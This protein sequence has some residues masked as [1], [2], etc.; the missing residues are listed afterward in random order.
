MARPIT[1]QDVAG[2]AQ[3]PGILLAANQATKTLTDNI[4]GMGD[5]LRQVGA[6]QK[7]AATGAAVASI[8]N[9]EN[10]MA[11]MA[12]LPQDNKFID[13]LAVSVAANA[14]TDQLLS[15]KQKNTSIAADELKM[16]DTRSEMADRESKRQIAVMIAPYEALARAGKDFDVDESDPI[17][18]TPAGFEAKKHLEDLRNTAF[19][20]RIEADKAAAAKTQARAASLQL[21]MTL[22]QKKADDEYVAWK[23]TDAGMAAGAAE[24]QDMARTIGQRSGAG[25]AYGFGLINRFAGTRGIASEGELKRHSP[26]GIPYDSTIHALTA[27][28]ARLEKEKAVATRDLQLAAAGARAMEKNNYA[29]MAAEALNLAVLENNTDMASGEGW[30]R[31]SKDSQDVQ[32]H[33]DAA[34]D[35]AR[36]I[37]TDVAT[38]LKLPVP[39]KDYIPLMPEQEANIAELTLAG[40][41]AAAADLTRQY[42][43]FNLVGGNPGLAVVEKERT[44]PFDIAIEENR[45]LSQKT[46]AAAV[47]GK[48]IPNE[49]VDAYGRTKAGRVYNQVKPEPWDF[50]NRSLQNGQNQR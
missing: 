34:A 25:E 43:A 4:D 50:V 24:D 3:T 21:E 38:Q 22:A 32:D 46:E 6:D 40:N 12:A 9:A 8:A 49:A 41:S 2:P 20:Q 23:Q 37:V 14:R 27:D 1:W 16:Q 36:S 47:G 10:P 19:N 35:R 39:G 5:V 15:T 18:Q 29:G 7:E 11:A 44:A 48:A 33:R 30:F 17:W 28:T 45:R 31:L 26:Q 42:V 13:P